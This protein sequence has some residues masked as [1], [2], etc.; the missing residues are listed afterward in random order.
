MVLK[1]G[2]VIAFRFALRPL[3]EVSAWGADRPVLHWFALTEGRCSLEVDG[4]RL[5]H[6]TQ[7]DRPGPCVDYYLARSG[8]TFSR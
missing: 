6:Q 2:P 8:R 7:V 5:L 4:H 1:T 3:D